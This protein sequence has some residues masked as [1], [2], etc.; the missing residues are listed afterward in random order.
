MPKKKGSGAKM[1]MSAWARKGS[2]EAQKTSLPEEEEAYEGEYYYEQEEEALGGGVAEETL[3]EDTNVSA[4]KAST[5]AN[6][7]NVIY[8]RMNEFEAVNFAKIVN[9]EK[10]GSGIQQLHCEA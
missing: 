1:Q 9:A 5:A 10:H 7:S 6:M 2:S 4:N 8:C 3:I